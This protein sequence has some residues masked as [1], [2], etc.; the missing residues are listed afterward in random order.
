MPANPS[1]E[2]RRAHEKIDAEAGLNDPATLF[3]TIPEHNVDIEDIRP[4]LNM[5][6]D[7]ATTKNAV[8]SSQEIILPN[9][10]VAIAMFGDQH[11][12]GK[13]DYRRLLADADLVAGTPNMFVIQGGDVADN[14]IIG[15]L[16][17]VQKQ[18]A[19]TYDMELRAAIWW[20]QRVAPS[21]IVWCGGNHES[22]TRKVSGIDFWRTKLEHCKC[23]YDPNQIRFT[24]KHCGYS[25][26]WMVRHKW[27]HS[28][29]FNPTHG[30]E[31]GYDRVAPFD[32]GVGFHTHVATLCRPFIR[33]GKVRYATLIGTYKLRDEYARELGFPN[34]AP[35][36]GSG[37]YV[38]PG[39]GRAIWEDDLQTAA[40]ILNMYR[41]ESQ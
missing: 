25:W 21:M 39:D 14:Y 7:R 12:G 19:T 2:V 26:E 27:R 38:F 9:K 22:W 8:Q 36:G 1:D 30:I 41:E 34:T 6:G 5:I 13:C 31:V 4:Y 20:V 3:G 28:S 32:I 15:K 40:E 24:L 11:F 16:I 23:L 33:D 37:A 18:Q 29:V 17:A 10:P 35:N